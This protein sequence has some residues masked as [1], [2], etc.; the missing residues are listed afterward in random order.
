MRES[1][2]H[3]NGLPSWKKP[4]IAE[5]LT[6]QDTQAFPLS[7]T[8]LNTVE[9]IYKVEDSTEWIVEWW[10]HIELSKD[11]TMVIEGKHEEQVLRD[12][13][14]EKPWRYDKGKGP[15]NMSPD[16]PNSQTDTRWAM[17]DGGVANAG[18]HCTRT[19]YG[20][21]I[22]SNE[23]MKAWGNFT[24]SLSGRGM[25]EGNNLYMDST[26][27]AESRG[28][29]ATMTRIISS[30]ESFQKVKQIDHA[31]DNEVVV[32]IYSDRLKG[33]LCNRLAPCI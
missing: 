12:A 25:V 17:S 19:G 24:Y 2:R 4:E 31:A 15:E 30:L 7:T 3:D 10:K 8:L 16:E 27:P 13:E 6:I 9:E 22:R 32:D 21:V 33:A 29:L 20:Y 23:P 1:T 11:D 28:L 14:N 26:R 18:T 5:C